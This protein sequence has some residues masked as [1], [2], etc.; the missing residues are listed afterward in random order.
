MTLRVTSRRFTCISPV[1]TIRLACSGKSLA[2]TTAFTP[3]SASA[4]RV[5]IDLMIACGST[6]TWR[7][8]RIGPGDC[9]FG[10]LP[11]FGG[12]VEDR[13]DD[14][15]V[16]GAAAK[17][18]GQPVADFGFGR[19]GV[20][21]EQRARRHQEARRADAALECGHLDELLLQGMQLV[22]V[23]HAFDGLDL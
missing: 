5:S 2:V 16:T 9:S 20:L 21:G 4:F 14:L 17:I 6:C 22:A 3:G 10:G 7:W 13:S 19:I 8:L 11:H 15:V 12:H 23:G 1:G 18:A